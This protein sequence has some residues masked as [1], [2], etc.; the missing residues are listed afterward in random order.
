MKLY[1]TR[2]TTKRTIYS[3][4]TGHW[5]VRRNNLGTHKSTWKWN[6]HQQKCVVLV[7][8][9]QSTRAEFAIMNSLTE[10]KEYDKL[11]IMKNTHKDS[12][13]RHMHTKKPAQQTCRYYC[14][15]QPPRQCLAYG[16][17]C[18][19]CNKIGHFR[20]VCRG[21]RVRDVNEMEQKAVQ[22][23]V[24]EKILTQCS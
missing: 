7:K 5:Y 18:T 3:W 22:H 24:E 16:M 17:T 2:Q 1:V 8:E 11:K 4:S 10:V 14:C 9:S 20:E 23:C 6:N 21:W 15:S 19:E 12:P 13:R